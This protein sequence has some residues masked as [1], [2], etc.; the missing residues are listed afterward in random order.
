MADGAAEPAIGTS[1]AG[2]VIT[3]GADT[4]IT[5]T[6]IP[7]DAA[8]DLWVYVKDAAG[9]IGK[10]KIDIP[11]FI[12]AETPSITAQPQDGS[13]EAG[14]SLSLSVTANVT[15]GGNLTYQWYSNETDSVAG[16]I[17]I[18]GAI[19]ATYTLLTDTA[20][21]TYYYVI[22]SNTNNDVNGAVTAS[23]TSDTAKVIVN[24]IADAET[25]T[26]PVQPQDGSV[27]S[28][29]SLSLSVTANVT[30]GGTLSYQWYSNET[31]SI[32]G[33]T[34]IAGA[35][36][37]TY[38]PPTD[39]TGTVYYYVVVTN[40]NDGASGAKTATATS[41]AAAVTVT[42][43]V[44]PVTLY[45]GTWSGSGTATVRVEAQRGSFLRLMLNGAEVS[46]ASYTVTEGS[47][48]ITLREGYLKTLKNGTYIFRAEFTG[49]YA[50]LT[51]SVNVKHDSIPKTGDSGNALLWLIASALPAIGLIALLWRKRR[52]RV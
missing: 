39:T 13:V 51:L 11:A 21:T 3:A 49:G 17:P 50:D 26:I 46:A 10:L 5:L 33:G 8:R 23:V 15:D 32:A 20:G 9:N 42:P 19:S 47:T 43:V 38:T 2:I 41:S 48:I 12:N 7:S 37:A 24:P 45:F 30:D 34:P 29:G 1:G 25:P 27:E 6:G 22:I 31:D 28:G 4:T 18:E 52:A 14:G 40:T 16:G 44:Y 35:I 36:Y